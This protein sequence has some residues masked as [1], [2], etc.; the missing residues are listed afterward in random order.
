MECAAT[1]HMLFCPACAWLFILCGVVG[2]WVR[3]MEEAH[4]YRVVACWIPECYRIYDMCEC[5]E[6]FRG[7]RRLPCWRVRVPRMRGDDFVSAGF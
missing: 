1:R 3:L 6:A 4:R 7:A 5:E 2:V